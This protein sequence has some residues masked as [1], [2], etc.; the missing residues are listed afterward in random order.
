MTRFKLYVCAAAVAL[1]AAAPGHAARAATHDHG[2]DHE[3]TCNGDGWD[4]DRASHC[5]IREAAIKDFGGRLDVD[6]GLNGGVSVRGWDRNEVV[7]RAKV[8]TRADTDEQAAAL[9][10]RVTIETAGG[11]VRAAG[12]EMRDDVSWSVSFQISVPRR[13]DVA[14]R[15]TNGGIAISDVSGTIQFEALNGG[16]S[17]RDLGG[18]VS[19]HTTN[20]GLAVSLAGDR[21]DGEALDVYTIN[22]GVVVTMPAGYSA[23]F[24]T[25]TVHGNLVLDFPVTLQGKLTKEFSTTLGSGGPLVRARTTNGGVVV[26]QAN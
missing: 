4:G 19:G 12:P 24:E 5:E 18:D 11:R 14:L 15:T 22:G 26:R 17:L 23:R 1:L 8:Q 21:W 13:T 6:P 7:V 9:A 3:L 2:D 16:V 10:S 25:G 20:G